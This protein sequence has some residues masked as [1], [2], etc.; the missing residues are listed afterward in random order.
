MVALL[1]WRQEDQKLGEEGRKEE[2]RNK[3]NVCHR[4][5]KINPQDRR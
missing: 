1:K 2:E 4:G 5:R 3:E